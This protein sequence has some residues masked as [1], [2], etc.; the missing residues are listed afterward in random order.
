MR[1]L[2]CEGRMLHERMMLLEADTIAV[3]HANFDCDGCLR[4]MPN[5]NRKWQF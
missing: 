1:R 5:C 4:N 3:G 2:L